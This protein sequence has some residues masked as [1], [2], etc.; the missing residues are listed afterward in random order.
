MSPLAA[1]L[2]L[3]VG[4]SLGL[5]GG[6]GSI[7]TLPILLYVVGM[8]AKEAIATSLLVVGVASFVATLAHAREHRVSFKLALSFG[9]ASMSSAYVAGRFAH[10][11]PGAWL[12]AGFTATMLVTGAEQC[13]EPHAASPTRALGA[14]A[15]VGAL[16]GLVGAGGGFLI[17]PALSMFA[18]LD[19]SRA[20]GTSLLVIT[21]NSLAGFAGYLGHVHID[22]PA[23]ALV[24]AM[25]ALGSV[26]GSMLAGRLSP[27]LLRRGFAGFVLVMG[28]VMAIQQL[29]PGL[30]GRAAHT[31]VRAAPT[32]AL[33]APLATR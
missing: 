19:M 32:L 15:G 30:L 31:S 8:P 3:L 2:A 24:T 9:L 16:T 29:G 6:G 10:Y 28:V 21:L 33:K 18:G 13:E 1:G 27:A 20:V 22:V 17:V 25:A 23:A 14:G 11:L 5:L 7:L 12:L 4:L 26:V